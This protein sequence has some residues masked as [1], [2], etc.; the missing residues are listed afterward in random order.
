MGVICDCS[1]NKPS[2]NNDD[3][4][5]IGENLY[6]V[7]TISKHDTRVSSLKKQSKSSNRKPSTILSNLC[8]EF[9]SNTQLSKVP[10]KLNIPTI[11]EQEQDEQVSN[12]IYN[13]TN[14]SLHN[15]KPNSKAEKGKINITFDKS[16][17]IS[18]K[19][20][21]ILD[22][23]KFI[24]YLGKGS[25]GCVYKAKHREI[26]LYSA[27]KKITKSLVDLS[28]YNETQILKTLDHPNIIKLLETYQDEKYYY[29][30]EEYCAGGNLYDYIKMQKVFSEKKA[31][32]IIL[33]ILKAVNYLHTNKIVHRDLKPENIVIVSSPSKGKFTGNLLNN[34]KNEKEK[35]NELSIKLIDFGTSTRIQGRKLK[36]ELGTIYY[37]APEVFFGSYDEKCDIWSCGIILYTIFCGFPPVRSSKEEDIKRKIIENDL[38]FSRK[39]WM[40]VSR[41][42]RDF[43]RSLLNYDPNQRPSASEAMKS[44]WIVNTLKSSDDK[45]LDNDIMTNLIK[46]HSTIVLEKAV[47]AYLTG[48]TDNI[49]Q[50]ILKEFEKIDKNGDGLI[51]KEELYETLQSY[52]PDIEAEKMVSDIFKQ[53]D[54]NDDGYLSY[55]E[56]MAVN[57][58]N[59][60]NFNNEMFKKAFEMF[61]LDGNGYITKEELAEKFSSK[62]EV[63]DTWENIINKVD[64]DGDGRINIDEFVEMMEKFLDTKIL[65]N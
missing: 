11:Q 40:K 42:A 56:F 21:S 36:Q 54:F 62:M 28:F 59:K 60:K 58:K 46:F 7:R 34:R 51:S 65:A 19:S 23:Y 32:N 1:C 33:Q 25:Y 31:A 20:N 15:S 47:L 27:I 41:E 44:T 43:V 22:Q 52:Y 55:T 9:N 30:V 17:F 24:D 49:D 35:S 16:N 38:D 12:Q 61:D 45:L 63:E 10:D 18:L 3:E 26:E 2:V 8:Y 6:V 53:V 14:M 4:I 48:L 57:S 37:I 64:K 29:L 5:Q 13:T 39:E 50:N